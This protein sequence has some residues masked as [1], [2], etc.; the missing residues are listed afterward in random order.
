MVIDAKIVN[1]EEQIKKLYSKNDHVN[2][3]EIIIYGKQTSVHKHNEN[4]YI[5]CQSK[6]EF[7]EYLEKERDTRKMRPSLPNFIYLPGN[8]HKSLNS[9]YNFWGF[10]KEFETKNK[11]KTIE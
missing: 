11:Q 8:K 7:K 9:L 2:I 10:R 1:F 4:E 3:K 6:D 5:V